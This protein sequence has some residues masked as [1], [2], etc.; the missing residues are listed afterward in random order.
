MPTALILLSVTAAG[1]FDLRWRRIPNWLVLATIAASLIWHGLTGG[2]SGLWM[3]VAGLLVGTAILFPLFLMRGMGAGDVKL[4]GALGAAV[5]FKHVLT[6]F[7][8]SAIIAGVMAVV[9]VL[10]ARAIVSTAA[11]LWDLSKRFVR[12]R[13][14]P[15]PALSV[16]NQQALA[17]PFGLSVAIATWVFVLFG[18]Q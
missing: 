16:D 14:S 18:R 9:R 7:V 10:F 5:T 15:H 8:L 17:I 1:L 6:L 4:F 12:G 11:N 3:S 13:F 2:L